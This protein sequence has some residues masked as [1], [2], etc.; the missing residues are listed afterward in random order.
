MLL[1]NDLICAG[2]NTGTMVI[3]AEITQRE[4]MEGGGKMEGEWTTV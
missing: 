4:G 1:G 3:V 2:Q